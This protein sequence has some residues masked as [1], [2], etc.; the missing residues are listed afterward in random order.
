MS[1]QNLPHSDESERALLR[2]LMHSPELHSKV[3]VLVKP[4]DFYRQT[5][6]WY[7][8]AALDLGDDGGLIA[9]RDAIESANGSAP[10]EVSVTHLTELFT[11]TYAIADHVERYAAKVVE[12][13]RRREA[14]R[15]G[16][17][18]AALAS[19]GTDLPD[20]ARAFIAAAK[21]LEVRSTAQLT[22]IDMGTI[23][24]AGVEPVPWLI[25]GWLAEGEICILAGE[26]GTGKSVVAMDLALSLTT[27]SPW[28]GYFRVGEERRVLYVDEENPV[29]VARQRVQ[30]MLTGKNL[31]DGPPNLRYLSK[32]GINLD[33]DPW[34]AAL[35]SEM[36]DFKPHV[37]I[38]DSLVRFHRRDENS[39]SDMAEFFNSRIRPLCNVYGCAIVIL[40]HMGKPS[41]ERKDAGHRVRGASEKAGFVDELWTLEGQRDTPDRV[42]SHHKSR[43][44][45]LQPSMALRWAV[46]DD[47][48][49]ASI[50][51]TQEKS[52]A[53]SGII[54]TLEIVSD[55]GKLQS[56]LVPDLEAQGVVGRTARHFL[57]RLH[58][59]GIVKRR[60][61]GQKTVRYWL[62]RYAPD[63]AE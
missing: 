13:S 39:N 46:S 59:Q 25:P 18:V 8:E 52:S 12:E 28:M 38:L 23:F 7:Y 32:N 11:G 35:E 54:R 30:Q 55:A 19:E 63:G 26:W 48:T 1:A 37:L 17:E 2:V 27:L 33:D 50:S 60:K 61:A 5:H 10:K 51:C 3:R 36:A 9:L 40:D 4:H 45:E 43:Y 14:M 34:R 57:N 49:S 6:R 24:A 42:F 31:T 53:E 41:K 29:G 20:V 47:K 56:D 22:R 16:S 44:D 15:F 62:S 58:A 21:R